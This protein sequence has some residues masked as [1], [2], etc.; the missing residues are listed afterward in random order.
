MGHWVTIISV[1][2]ILASV[3]YLH[4]MWNYTRGIR[5]FTGQSMIHLETIADLNKEISLILITNTKYLQIVTKYLQIVT[6]HI[7][8]ISNTT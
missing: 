7:N 4:D 6:E 5:E 1:I 2:L 3:L 8:N